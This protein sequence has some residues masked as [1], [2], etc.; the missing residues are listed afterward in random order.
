MNV[1][2]PAN[3]NNLTLK[4]RV[5][6]DVWRLALERPESAHAFQRRRS[7]RGRELVVRPQGPHHAG[8]GSQSPV[9]GR[10]LRHVLDHRPPLLTILAFFHSFVGNWGIA[11]P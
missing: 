7:A 2:A 10:E 11:I 9:A 3:P 4:G 6:G 8:H 5:Q 1:T